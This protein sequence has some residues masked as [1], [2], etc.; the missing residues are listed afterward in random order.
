MNS[1]DRPHS[2]TTAPCARCGY[3]RTPGATCERCAAAV[4]EPFQERRGAW[5]C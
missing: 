5:A 1:T 2:P 4:G 3:P